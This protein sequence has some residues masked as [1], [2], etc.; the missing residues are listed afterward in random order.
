M[1]GLTWLL[2]RSFVV[3]AITTG[4]AICSAATVMG[5]RRS[6]MT[7]IDVMSVTAL[8]PVEARVVLLASPRSFCTGVER[9]CIR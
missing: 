9:G 6:A 5:R 7:T 2:I 3:T 1:Q 4:I 8:D